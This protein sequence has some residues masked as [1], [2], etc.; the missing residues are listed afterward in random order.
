QGGEDAV[1]RRT[2][3]Q[4]EHIALHLPG[5]RLNSFGGFVHSLLRGDG[6][7]ARQQQCHETS[8]P[9]S[10][11]TVVHNNNSTLLGWK[12][13]RGNDQIPCGGAA[14]SSAETITRS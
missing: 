3:N 4:G 6:R 1:L 11:R 8:H 13:L 9:P 5:G 12:A 14:R 2:V 7:C 10:A